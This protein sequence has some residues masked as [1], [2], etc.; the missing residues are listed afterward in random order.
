[1]RP[2][3]CITFHYNKE[4]KLRALSTFSKA[5]EMLQIKQVS[6]RGLAC[7]GAALNELQK[8]LPKSE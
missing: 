6:L 4:R 1:M 8:T 7:E 3:T 2:L 5:Y